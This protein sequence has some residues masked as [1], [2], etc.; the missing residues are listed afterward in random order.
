LYGCVQRQRIENPVGLCTDVGGR[1]DQSF[2]DSA[3][4]GLEMW[5][6]GR[7][8]TA[9]GYAPL[10]PAQVEASIPADLKALGV[11]VAPVR[12]TP[13][14]LQAKAQEDYEPNLQLL[15]DFGAKL[16][17]GVGFMLENAVEA[18]A[19]ANPDARFLLIDSPLLDESGRP[20]TLPNVRTVTFREHEGSFL[21]G[22]LAALATK[23]GR[24]GF[25]GGVDIPLIRKFEA[26]YRAG[27]RA[28]RPD[29]TVLSTF[30][31]KFD[32]SAAGKRVAAD[33]LGKGADVLFHASGSCG[34]GVIAAARDAGRLAIGVDSDQSP[35]APGAVL[36]SMIKHVDLVVY[37]A[38][39]DALDGLFRAGD[40]NIGLAEGGVGYAP[41]AIPLPD[42]ENA[43]ARVEALR[44]AVVAG[45]IRVPATIEELDQFQAPAPE[46]LADTPPTSPASAPAPSPAQAPA[47]RRT[48]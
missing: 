17:V 30:T 29:V 43:I 13:V 14:V 38:S 6:A 22:A 7:A 24:V 27:V 2:N 41:V 12:A 44:R 26:G 45:R 9:S 21:V 48:P 28:V 10:T 5:L 40:S 39:R 25:V 42:R 3:L 23:S 16:V 33:L 46:L 8:Y 34:L 31:G 37:Q 36:T 11:A 15:A 47:P 18:V 1:G 19:K 20:Y 4:R 35:M 32:D